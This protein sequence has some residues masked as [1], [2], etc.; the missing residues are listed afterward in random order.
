MAGRWWS[1]AVA[2]EDAL[3]TRGRWV[4]EGWGKPGVLE[5]TLGPL[6]WCGY[7]RTEQDKVTFISTL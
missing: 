1:S 7:C 2:A 6:S 4:T 3:E 5:E